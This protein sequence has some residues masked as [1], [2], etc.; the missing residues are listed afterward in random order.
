[1]LLSV[2]KADTQALCMFHKGSTTITVLSAVQ[3]FYQP[4]NPN[5]MKV[6]AVHI[7]M[8]AVI[9][10]DII[11]GQ[12]MRL[13]AQSMSIDAVNAV[14]NYILTLTTGATRVVVLM[15]DITNLIKSM[16]YETPYVI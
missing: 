15:E 10:M 16:E 9:T 11:H 12:I 13:I 4:Q 6:F 5:L 1:M 8:V 2:K 3:W 14:C 7:E